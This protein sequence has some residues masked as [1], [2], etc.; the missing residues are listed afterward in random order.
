[1]IGI[2]PALKG[3]GIRY[4][5][6]PRPL[7]GEVFVIICKWSMT[8]PTAWN[9]KAKFKVVRLAAD[10]SELGEGTFLDG[11]PLQ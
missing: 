10:T 6:K 7:K 4:R 8:H 2:N 9:R 11:M 5:D 3:R 1:M